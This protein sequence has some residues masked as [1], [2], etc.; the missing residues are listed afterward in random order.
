LKTVI[1]PARNQADLEDLPEEVRQEIT[2]VFAETVDDVL[3][4]SLE[5]ATAQEPQTAAEADGAGEAEP[6]AQPE[7]HEE[8]VPTEA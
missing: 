3:Q 7:D 1:L 8:E 2:F 4:A 5:P 6:V